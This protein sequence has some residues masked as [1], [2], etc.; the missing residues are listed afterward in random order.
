M[1]STRRA[2]VLPAA[3][4]AGCVSLFDPFLAEPIDEPTA[5]AD[6]EA[7][8]AELEAGRAVDAIRAVSFGIAEIS[9]D[10]AA[11]VPVVHVRLSVANR[12]D[13]VPW[14]VDVVNATLGR[15]GR[16]A[17]RPLFVNSDIATLP[18]ARVDGGEQRAIDLYFPVPEGIDASAAPGAL[19]LHARIDTPDRNL[20]WYA[21][22]GPP[23][24]PVYGEA[25]SAGRG[26]R[27][28]ADPD[29]AW[30]S[31]NRRSGPITHR[32]PREIVLTRLPRWEYVPLATGPRAIKNA[33]SRALAEIR[34]SPIVEHAWEPSLVAPIVTGAEVAVAPIPCA[35]YDVLVVDGRGDRCVLPFAHLC[36]GAETWSIDDVTLEH[37]A[38]RP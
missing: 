35:R 7:M 33:T 12:F 27:W 13:R 5:T 4:L 14:T 18:I 9:A 32:V 21:R 15:V 28:W 8:Y 29:H 22:V 26:A 20:L 2:L 19:E 3:L 37:C 11:P 10:G 38:W 36:F 23:E 34:L 6:D 24:S 30:P 25:Q 17:S 16:A 1:T 31:F